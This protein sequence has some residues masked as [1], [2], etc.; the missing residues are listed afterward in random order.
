MNSVCSAKPVL[1][2]G[3]IREEGANGAERHVSCE[4]ANISVFGRNGNKEL[5]GYTI[6]KESASL[7]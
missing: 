4:S 5:E 3:A 6:K 2:E 1:W 7:N